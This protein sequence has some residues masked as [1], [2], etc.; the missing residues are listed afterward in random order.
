M[1]EAESLDN[2]RGESVIPLI[3]AEH[4]ER[5]IEATRQTF[6]GNRTSVEFEMVGLKGTRRW[7]AALQVPLQDAQENIYALLSVT[8]DV[9]KRKRAETLAQQA[10]TGAQPD[11]A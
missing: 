4:R 8:R 11:E 2:I 6:Q 5:F 9:T 1:V 7:M 10:E 3:A